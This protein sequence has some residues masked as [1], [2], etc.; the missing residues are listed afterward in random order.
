MGRR[1]TGSRCSHGA[2]N[3]HSVSPNTDRSGAAHHPLPPVQTRRPTQAEARGTR[4][5]ALRVPSPGL[6]RQGVSCRRPRSE[7]RRGRGAGRGVC[8]H[9]WARLGRAQ[10][11]VPP[12]WGRE[13]RAGSKR[14]PWL[15]AVAGSTKLTWPCPSHDS[16]CRQRRRPSQRSL[17]A[18]AV[19]AHAHDSAGRRCSGPQQVGAE[20]PARGRPPASSKAG[21]RL[22]TP[23]RRRPPPPAWLR[24]TGPGG[25]RAGGSEDTCLS[26]GCSDRN[27]G[28]VLHRGV[29][30]SRFWGWKSNLKAGDGRPPSW[31]PGEGPPAS[32]G[33]GWCPSAPS[34]P[35]L[36]PRLLWFRCVPSLSAL[37]SRTNEGT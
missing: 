9:P 15:A 22:T 28:L 8:G 35:R 1:L 7:H 33:G 32:P 16:A 21:A 36:S 27:H 2:P 5:R 34:V 17:C 24:D 4:R 23:H 13:G 14:V 18:P 29:Y 37:L 11:G 30:P 31:G 6:E 10:R 20:G 12:G 19:F 3:T 25:L 26:P